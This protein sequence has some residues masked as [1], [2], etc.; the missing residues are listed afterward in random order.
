MEKVLEKLDEMLVSLKH[1]ESELTF[2]EEKNEDEE[3][4]DF[5]NHIA[6]E[7]GIKEKVT[8]TKVTNE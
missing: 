3:V 5:L 4:I 2:E 1:I 8:I 6:K 7:L